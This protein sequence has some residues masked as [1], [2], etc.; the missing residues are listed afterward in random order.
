M[1]SSS[2]TMSISRENTKYVVAAKMK[3]AMEKYLA[4]LLFACVDMEDDRRNGGGILR[5]LLLEE[6][7]QTIFSFTIF[8]FR[9]LARCF[10]DS[11]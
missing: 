4:K 9:T 2:G 1:D 5:D 10:K 8:F 6:H 11:T 7:G 3:K